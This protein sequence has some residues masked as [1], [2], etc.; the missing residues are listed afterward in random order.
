MA[1]VIAGVACFANGVLHHAAPASA[2]TGERQGLSKS[3]PSAT[4]ARD[5]SSPIFTALTPRY[6]TKPIADIRAGEEVVARDTTTGEMTT[7]KVLNAFRRVSTHLQILTVVD[8]AT[9]ETQ[10]IET[11]D[12]H[13]FWVSQRGDW[14]KAKELNLGDQF[15][16]AS[17]GNAVLVASEYEPHPEGIAVFNFEDFQDH[18]VKDC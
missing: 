3:P 2:Q 12:E 14:I 16:D 7:R 18:Y 4:A 1:C 8:P 13:P 10:T 5:L 17:G 9:Q 11:T 15:D 6:V